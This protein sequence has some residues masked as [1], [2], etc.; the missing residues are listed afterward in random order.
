M[1]TYRGRFHLAAIFMITLLGCLFLRIW[2]VPMFASIVCYIRVFVYFFFFSLSVQLRYEVP[3][4][5]CFFIIIIFMLFLLDEFW[6]CSW[7]QHVTFLFLLLNWLGFRNS[8]KSSVVCYFV[9]VLVWDVS[10]HSQSGQTKS[11]LYL[12]WFHICYQWFELL[13][14]NYTSYGGLIYHCCILLALLIHGTY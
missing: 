5:I 9:S 1:I 3:E 13:S 6:S 7:F 11:R 2:G 10:P 12:K 8:V 4:M 14:N